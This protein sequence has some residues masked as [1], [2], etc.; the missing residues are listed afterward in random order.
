MA[1]AKKQSKYPRIAY[2][3]CSACGNTQGP[4]EADICLKCAE[5]VLLGTEDISLNTAK[6]NVF[7]EVYDTGSY[8][9]RTR[10]DHKTLEMRVS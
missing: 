1:K 7:P 2:V 3:T 6:L 10:V 5:K 8:T 9:G 4:K